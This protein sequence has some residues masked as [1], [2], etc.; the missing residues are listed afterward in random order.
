MNWAGLLLIVAAISLL[1]ADMHLSA[2]GGLSVG[3]LICF[4]FGSV[5]LYSPFGP[6]S[7][8]LP[9]ASVAWPLV[10]GVTGMGA[11]LS[12]WI[13]STAL[14]IHN[15]API[16]GPERLI[17][18]RGLSHTPLDPEGTVQVRGQLWSARLVDGRLDSGVPVRVL[19][20]K[21]LTLEVEAAPDGVGPLQEP[22]T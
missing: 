15:Q 8:T 21:G 18:A 7:V 12:L 2:R 13:V 22:T 1:M 10:I 14:R 17:G 11:C 16:T 19:T 6:R 9:D 3:A 20:R 4:V 5:L